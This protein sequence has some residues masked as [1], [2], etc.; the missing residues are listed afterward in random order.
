[1]LKNAGISKVDFFQQ[2]NLKNISLVYSH[3]SLFFGV[4]YAI[5]DSGGGKF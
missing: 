4:L 3:R 1:M 5:R 2:D